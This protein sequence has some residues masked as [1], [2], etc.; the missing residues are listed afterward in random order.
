MKRAVLPFL[1]CAFAIAAAACAGKLPPVPT[2]ATPAFPD[3]VFPS[4]PQ[5]LASDQ[6]SVM[7][8]DRGWRFLQANDARGAER[9][10]AAALK[11]NAA[12][13]PAEAG[14][15][16]ASLA[17]KDYRAALG[18]FD[19]A[20]QHAPRYA[21]ALVGRGD[22]L[23]GAGRALDALKAFELALAADPSVAVARQR[24]QVLQLRTLQGQIAAARKA[25]DAGR[26]DDARQGYE[27]AIAAS[28]ESG[29]LY[30]DLAAVQRKQ[31]DGAAALASLRKAVSLDPAD[32][33]AYTQMGE[34]LE[35]SGDFDGAVQAYAQA[36]A[37]D[38]GDAATSRLERARERAI[39]A[40]LP[41]E[42]AEIAHSPRLA[43]ADLAAL[44]GVRFSA[45]LE[46]EP[47]R[48]SVVVTDARG[49]WAAPWIVPVV[50]AGVMEAFPNHTFRPRLGVSRLE[51]ARAAS[52]LLTIAAATRPGLASR[53]QGAAPRIADMPP[54]HLGYPA[55]AQAVAA[56]VMPLG[57]GGVFRPTDPVTGEDAVQVMDRVQALTAKP[58]G[59]SRGTLTGRT[60]GRKP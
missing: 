58:G 17:N 51:L 56:G 33:R 42:Y 35:A 10:F 9:E 23:L 12:F 30:R 4:V 47:G 29:F 1:V 34:L 26:L 27:R 8:Q 31:G 18:R 7:R 37:L 60:G 53:W 15:G 38:P 32:A 40:H 41:P 24:I 5:E 25:A 49:S 22:A 28:P 44:I 2:P 43:R 52:R 45:L 20:L 39:Q 50:R 54:T 57:E 19:R 21:P 36:A 48:D 59:S 11:R 55:A 14:L 16:Y 6:T 46:S 13:F 3:F